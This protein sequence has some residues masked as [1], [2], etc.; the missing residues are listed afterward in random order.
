MTIGVVVAVAEPLSR[1]GIS[2]LLDVR[3]D[4]AVLAQ[5][6]GAED[7]LKVTA[8]HLPDVLLL[9]PGVSGTDAADLIRQAVATGAASCPQRVVRV[10]V[11][12]EQ[13]TVALVTG[14]LRAGASGVVLTRSGPAALV[15]AVRATAATG[16]WLDPVVLRDLLHDLS[17]Q[18]VSGQRTAALVRR[19]TDRE[20]EVLELMAHGYDN[21]Q[22][23]RRLF[24]SGTTV[25]THVGRVLHKLG[26]GTR[27]H[28]VV[29]AYRCGLVRLEP[30]G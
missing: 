22:I 8:D 9:D 6:G 16:V 10:L 12:A 3:P 1:G 15:A 28:A 7:A 27:T 11:V 30:A 17:S 24:I 29:M 5:V 25:R 18:P 26:C 19:L 20:R 14:V 4:L 21:A 13:P 23:A 2:A